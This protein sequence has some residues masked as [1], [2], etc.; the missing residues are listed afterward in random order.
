MT[1]L[2]RA[3]PTYDVQERHSRWI[4]AGADRVWQA[5]TTLTLADL[6]LTRPLVAV[7]QLGRPDAPTTRNLFTDGPV[8]MLQQQPPVYAVGGAIS[9]PWQYR[10]Q[11]REVTTMAEFAAFE[12]PGWATYLTDFQLQP[13]DGGV[14]LTTVTRVHCTDGNARRRFLAYWLLI[15]A[16]SGLVRRDML[17]ATA[18]K[19]RR[20]RT[21][22]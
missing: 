7:R 11:R 2:E 8:R 18:R 3:L 9:R 14:R 10:P 15:R 6:P 22:D 4:D 5:L 16:P 21:A 13:Q 1:P 12:E 19:A 20:A 17:A